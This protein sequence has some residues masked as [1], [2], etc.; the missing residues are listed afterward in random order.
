MNLAGER[1]L[2]FK[3]SSQI[4]GSEILN[5]VIPNRNSVKQMNYNILNLQLQ[6]KVEKS[7]SLYL[8][9]L[10]ISLQISQS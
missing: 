8:L 6:F 5:M 9:Y 2:F 1:V 4:F 10:F 3:L 7:F